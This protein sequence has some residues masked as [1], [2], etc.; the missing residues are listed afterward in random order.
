MASYVLVSIANSKSK[1]I[2]IKDDSSRSA[3]ESKVCK[4]V[5]T[6][7]TCQ[8]IIKIHMMSKIKEIVHKHEQFSLRVTYVV[9]L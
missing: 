4:D 7:F 2:P 5:Q 9:M 1:G 6:A 8:T 3:A